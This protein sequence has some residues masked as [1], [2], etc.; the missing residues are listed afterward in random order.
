MQE[1]HQ[2][3]LA[4]DPK[5]RGFGYIV[6]EEPQ[7]PIDWGTV[8][9]RFNLHCRSIQRIKKLMDFYQPDVVILEG[10]KDS[11]RN[12]RTK[13]FISAMVTLSKKQ[14]VAVVQYSKSDVFDTFA[15]LGKRTKHEIATAIAE[16]FPELS[17]RLPNKRQNYETEAADYAI[18]DAA[19]LAI[20]HYYRTD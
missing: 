12:T 10:T 16:W 7:L 5:V 14:S 17:H 15:Q 1:Q 11:L 8:E 19:A 13:K 4:I 6:F 18:F 20:T 3:V 2:R 9:I